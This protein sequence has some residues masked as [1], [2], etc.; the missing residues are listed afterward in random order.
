M[1]EPSPVDEQS[2]DKGSVKSSPPKLEYKEK[3]YLLTFESNIQVIYK[4]TGLMNISKESYQICLGNIS[5]Q[6]ISDA[7]TRLRYKEPK[8]FDSYAT[9]I[10][11]FVIQM[12]APILIKIFDMINEKMIYS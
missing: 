2:P 10:H 6:Y 5:E 3:R 1:G 12:D 9:G 4:K 7:S 8:S 11:Y